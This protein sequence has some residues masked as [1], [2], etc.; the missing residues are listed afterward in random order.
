MAWVALVAL[1][2][3]Q[4][5]PPKAFPV[6]SLRVEGQK[7]YPADRI[8]A[9]T[10]LKTGAL[11]EPA[12]FEAARDRLLKSGAF[13]S[14]AMRFE[15]APG[16]KGYAVTFEVAEIAQ[17]YP[18]KFDRI[19]APESDMMEWLK[20][21][22]PL[23]GDRIPA[24]KEM[25]ERYQRHIDE[26]LES[27]GVKEKVRGRV[28]GDPNNLYVLFHP[29]GAPPVVAQV[30]FTNNKILPAEALA[31]AIYGVAIGV[32]YREE[33]FRQLLDGS[34]RFLYE[35]RGRVRVAFPK[36]Y[37]ASAQDVKGVAVTVEI[38]EGPS[39]DLRRARVEGTQTRDRELLEI[40]DLKTGDIYNR[41]EVE[42]S[43]QRVVAALRRAGY[44]RASAIIER[45]IDDA[46]RKVDVTVA[47]ESGPQFLFGKLVIQGLDILNEPPLRKLW[48]ME[49]GKP[50]NPEYP[51]FF[52]AKIRQEGVF[53]NL[54]RTRADLKVDDKTLTVDVTL[55]FFR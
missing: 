31:R 47:V 30:R 36:I 17:V 3:A 14:V 48:A 43:R 13:E 26:F 22:E 52:L 44:M 21:A 10:G 6:E 34:I 4:T 12:A 1:L 7:R 37:A 2:A 20:K 29:G 5:A 23:F 53:D 8:L 16:G 50:F 33:T 55:V 41:Q 19:P 32:E 42:A 35:D 24:T 27:K 28:T 9:L 51:D 15:P 49:S 11:A 46:E 38:D 39:Y 25:I 54:G 18:L 40:A 45:T